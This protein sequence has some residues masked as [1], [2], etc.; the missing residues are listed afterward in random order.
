IR[1]AGSGPKRSS[2]SG[3]GRE[4]CSPTVRGTSTGCV[5]SSGPSSCHAPTA[6]RRC[7]TG[8]DRS[9]RATCC[10]RTIRR[11]TR[12]EGGTTMALEKVVAAAVQ[13]TPEF[14]DREATV[15]KAVRLIK[16]ASGEGAG[17]IVFPET[18]IPTY[19][20]WVWRAP[21]WDG[22]SAELYALLLEN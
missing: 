11:A 10:R 1:C 12:A 16:E 20:D 21:A 14:L 3:S 9:G 22:P 18:F 5:A 19:P 6:R 7:R 2:S 13:A 8:S 17:L 15:E 4:R